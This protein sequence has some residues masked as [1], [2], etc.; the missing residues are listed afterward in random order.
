[1]LTV[2]FVLGPVPVTIRAQTV[3]NLE[4]VSIDRPVLPLHSPYQ[5]PITT[6]DARD[7]KPP[8]LFEVK[9][10]KDTPNVLIIM[11][12][13][14]DCGP[15]SAFGG[16]IPTPTFDRQAKNRLMYNRFHSTA[17]CSPT[18]QAHACQRRPWCHAPHTSRMTTGSLPSDRSRFHCG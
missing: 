13:D 12:D 1:V 3:M 18:L 14:P 17:P 6:L 9:A 5:K 15:T 7:V 10:P 2:F 16:M 8:P 11:I 4:N